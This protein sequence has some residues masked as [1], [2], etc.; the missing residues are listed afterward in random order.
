MLKFFRN[1]RK[2]LISDGNTGRYLKYAL[3]E[4]L[5]VVIGILI[6][7][8]INNWNEQ[9]KNKIEERDILE[10][11]KIEFSEN[12]TLLNKMV[13]LHSDMAFRLREL[14]EFIQP[15]P[16]SI[17]IQ[18][19]DSLMVAVIT[20]PEYK[21]VSNVVST[22]TQSGNL[23][24][25]RDKEVQDLI[26]S[27]TNSMGDYSHSIKYTIDH[28]FSYTSQFIIDNYQLKNLGLELGDKIVKRSAFKVDPKAI[29]SNPKF[30][31]Y[32]ELRRANAEQQ[33]NHSTQLFEIQ[34][35]IINRIT[36]LLQ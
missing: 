24:K 2:K 23:E 31:N 34:K 5:L 20:N 17:N 35:A 32:V 29:L 19:M 27:W 26:F 8:Q 9:R 22:L 10:N 36:E 1:I 16:P 4:I 3:G 25:I 15:N 30:E 21:P 13:N 18:K 14:T 12:Q 33:L 11:L 7:L 28:Y 6:A